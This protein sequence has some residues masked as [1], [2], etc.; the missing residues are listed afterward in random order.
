MSSY[1][2]TETITY[3]RASE[4]FAQFDSGQ[5][6]FHRRCRQ[7]LFPLEHGESVVRGIHQSIW[8][9]TPEPREVKVRTSHR[10]PPGSWQWF[11]NP[12]DYFHA[13]CYELAD[14]DISEQFLD[15]MWLNFELPLEGKG[16]EQRK[17][18]LASLMV[19]DLRK[20]NWPVHLPDEILLNVSGHMVREYAVLAAKRRVLA[21]PSPRSTPIDFSCNVYGRYRVFEGKLYLQ[22]LSSTDLSTSQGW[23]LLIEGQEKCRDWKV[24]IAED[25]HGIRKIKSL[26]DGDVLSGSIPN[27]EGLWWRSFR[28]VDEEGNWKKSVAET[29]GYKLRDINSG[30]LPLCIGIP[31]VA[32]AHTFRWPTW[33]IPNVTPILT[34][35]W[36]HYDVASHLRM[37]SFSCNAPDTTGYSVAITPCG[38]F[39]IHAH[40]KG[41]GNAEPYRRLDPIKGPLYWFYMPIDKGEYLTEVCRYQN[42]AHKWDDGFTLTTNRGRTTVFGSHRTLM[43]TDT[44]FERIHSPPKTETQIYFNEMGAVEYDRKARVLAVENAQDRVLCEI[45]TNILPLQDNPALNYDHQSY[46][47]SCSLVGLAKVT[48]CTDKNKPHKPIIGMLCEYTDGH[49]ECVGQIRFD[50]VDELL[51]MDGAIGLHFAICNQQS[52]VLD[53]RNCWIY[54]VPH[55]STTTSHVVTINTRPLTLWGPGFVWGCIPLQGTLEWWF[56][57]CCTFVGHTAEERVYEIE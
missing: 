34:E 54:N 24:L 17:D 25:H 57:P 33:N 9:K 18:N 55:V 43:E 35:G 2:H 7:C 10:R 36:Y 5:N 23:E 28:P 11:R 49:R 31:R 4:P 45:P 13:R 1:L 12:W 22:E 20:Q 44:W 6:V 42:P 50:M 38:F 46:Y 37:R 3:D 40:R 8:E 52:E 27:T 41:E 26:R 51:D 48:L 16:E 21:P 32:A 14:F 39:H 47:S 56:T 53:P 30:T 15:S 29:D 19:S